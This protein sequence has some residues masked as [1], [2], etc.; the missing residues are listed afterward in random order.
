M[1]MRVIRTSAYVRRLR[2][3]IRMQQIGAS[4]ANLPLRRA[5]KIVGVGLHDQPVLRLTISIALRALRRYRFR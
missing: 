2:V 1:E 3:R 5:A 4:V